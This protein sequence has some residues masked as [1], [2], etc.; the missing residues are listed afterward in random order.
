MATANPGRPAP[1]PRSQEPSFAEIFRAHTPFLWRTLIGVGVPE[2]DAEDLC[3]EVML[4]A[5]R[6]LPEFD[7][8]SLRAWL[9]GI[10]VRVASDYRRSARVRREIAVLPPDPGLAAD[11]AIDIEA[12][13][14]EA[15][16]QR[17]LAS[18]D[19]DKRVVFVLFEIEELT[20]REIAQALDTPLQTIY[21]RLNAARQ[22][23]RAAFDARVTEG[24]PRGA[25]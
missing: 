18:L 4:I 5:Y 10:C 24:G 14:L 16:L 13:E 23:V 7:G 1:P 15:R 9:W 25:R 8:Q 22:H 2:R 12:R 20:L 19:Y 3:Q 21:S 11:R 6:R 17:A